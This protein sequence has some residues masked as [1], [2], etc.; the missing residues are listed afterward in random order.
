MTRVIADL[1]KRWWPVALPG[2]LT[3]VLALITVWY[4]D[5]ISYRFFFGPD[6]DAV[7]YRFVTSM[8]DVWHSQINHYF[9]ANGRF[10]CH[11]IVQVCCQLVPRWLWSLADAAV[12]ALLPC[13]LLR[14]AR[15]QRNRMAAL[16]VTVAITWLLT[17]WLPFNPSYHVNYI[18][19]AAINATLLIIWLSRRHIPAVALAGVF[20]FAFVA[21]EWNE[22]FSIPVSLGLFVY[23]LRHRFRVT[24][25]QWA[26]GTA[27]AAGTLTVTLAPGNFLRLASTQH[28][29]PAITGIIESGLPVLLVP[30]ICGLIY[31]LARLCGLRPSQVF[32]GRR[33]FLLLVAVC[34]Y[35]FC[36]AM[37]FPSGVRTSTCGA[38]ALAALTAAIVSESGRLRTA[39]TALMW[40][41]FAAVT[42]S[43][44]REVRILNAK[45]TA[46]GEGYHASS[47]GTV[48]LPDSLFVPE[49]RD[50]R[51]YITPWV[52][53]ERASDPTK[54]EMRIWP[55]T[56]ATVNTDADTNRI[57]P[58]GPQAWLLIQSRRHPAVFTV[59]KTLL[60][61]FLDKALP[62]RSLDLSARSD[63]FIDTTANLTFAAYTNE[64][65]YIHAT[66][67]LTPQ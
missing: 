20:V 59:H 62:P 22:S 61:G 42:W 16:S 50:A 47:D 41:I 66:V 64:R 33:R 25:T 30:A 28:D 49:M 14:L 29:A 31:L 27:Y 58:L 11:Y 21:G 36:A 1:V 67:T 17:L 35:V 55:A 51:L 60:P 56:L 15:P 19:G 8:S 13:L 38:C 18:W 34:S 9:T 52:Q 26:A 37:G 12:F 63:I 54:P 46:I 4:R 53:I 10:V 43:D 24:P 32:D 44:I 7:T 45:Y 6:P 40:L 57:V 23:A 65:P 3:F 5:A 48:V 39:L 2:A